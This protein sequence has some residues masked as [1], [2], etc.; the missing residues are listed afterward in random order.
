MQLR[1]WGP[2]TDNLL[3]WESDPLTEKFQ[4][5][6]TRRCM[7]TLIHIFVTSFVEIRRADVTRTMRG[8]TNRKKLRM[9][10]LVQ[11]PWS[12]LAENFIGSLLPTPHPSAKFRPNSSSF[13]TDVR[14]CLLRSLQYQ[15]DL[16]EPMG[17]LQR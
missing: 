4:T 10:P 8:I 6:A 7:R 2:K 16:P 14:E 11:R 1:K 9:L 12:Y 17:S 5:F 13:L 3:F 15:C